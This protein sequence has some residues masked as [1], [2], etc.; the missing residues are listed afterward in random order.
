MHVNLWY[1]GT[2]LSENSTGRHL[3]NAMCD[4]TQF[5]ISTIITETHAEHLVKPWMDNIVLSF[6]MVTILVVDANSWFKIIFKDMFIALVIIYWPPVRGNQ[7]AWAWKSIT[8]FSTKRK[9]SQVKIKA[10][11]MSFC[12]MWKPL[13]IPGI[14]PQSTAHIFSEVLLLSVHNS[15]FR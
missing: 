5:V 12:I 3:L 7:K 14:V 1:P 8:A 13:S 4:L 9:Q 11:M 15:V 6:G 10:C 2:A